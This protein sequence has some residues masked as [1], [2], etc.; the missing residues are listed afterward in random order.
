MT[1][2]KLA[3]LRINIDEL[4]LYLLTFLQIGIFDLL[5]AS[6]RSPR[7]AVDHPYQEGTRRSTHKA[8][9]KKSYPDRLCLPQA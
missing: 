6:S 9:P 1:E 8:S 4:D 7:Y 3:C 2:L 5:G